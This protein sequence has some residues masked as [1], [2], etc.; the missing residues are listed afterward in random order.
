MEGGVGGGGEGDGHSA[1]GLK[2]NLA[3]KC[4]LQ[5]SVKSSLFTCHCS[6]SNFQEARPVTF[7]KWPVTHAST[8]LE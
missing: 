6:F 7:L 8:F 4:K 5:R 3:M 2:L 1:Y